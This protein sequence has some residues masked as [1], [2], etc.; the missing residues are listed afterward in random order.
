[1]HW[2]PGKAALFAQILL[3]L[4]QYFVLLEKPFMV[5][6]TFGS[7]VTP[8]LVSFSPFMREAFYSFVYAPPAPFFPYSWPCWVFIRPFRMLLFKQSSK[9][10]VCLVSNWK[11]KAWCK[12]KYWTKCASATKCSITHWE[13]RVSTIGWRQIGFFL[14]SQ[15]NFQQLFVFFFFFGTFHSLHESVKGEGG[16]GEGNRLLGQLYD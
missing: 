13:L 12:H 3:A 5:C 9:F 1:M 8:Q 11:P 2:M 15:C 7:K 6:W 4:Q 14:G 10:C 16:R